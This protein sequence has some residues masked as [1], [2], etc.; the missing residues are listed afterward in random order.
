MEQ[1]LRSWSFFATNCTNLHEL[2][3]MKFVPIREICGEFRSLSVNCVSPVIK[4]PRSL[5]LCGEFL[6]WTQICDLCSWDG[7]HR[8]ERKG[9]KDFLTFFAFF[10]PFA[11]LI[12]QVANLPFHRAARIIA[13]L[14]NYLPA[15]ANR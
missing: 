7:I 13:S 14:R 1:E 9:R 2:E 11:V 8:K 12:A 10:A 4:T 15:S 5:R 3:E 6:Q